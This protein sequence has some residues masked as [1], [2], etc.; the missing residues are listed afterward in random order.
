M[1]PLF[2]RFLYDLIQVGSHLGQQWHLATD[3]L[4]L[5]QVDL[6]DADGRDLSQLGHDIAPGVDD[7]GVGIG[8]IIAIAYTR[9]RGADGKYLVVQRAAAES[10]LPVR[11][12]VVMLKAAGVKSSVPPAGP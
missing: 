6:C 9:R 4:N 1:R 10:K 2:N 8:D 3:V 5:V 12:A 11:T 7:D